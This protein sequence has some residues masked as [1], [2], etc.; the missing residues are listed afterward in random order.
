MN[1]AT[2]EVLKTYNGPNHALICA[3]TKAYVAFDDA[4][5]ELREVKNALTIEGAGRL[6]ALR[7]DAQ[8]RL[9][10]VYAARVAEEVKAVDEVIAAVSQNAANAKH[11][12]KSN[13]VAG[14]V[15]FVE[16]DSGEVLQVFKR[17]EHGDVE[18]K[19]ASEDDR[20]VAQRKATKVFNE[21]AERF[22]ILRG[23]DEPLDAA[24]RQNE[25]EDVEE[26]PF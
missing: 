3:L 2:Y 14:R 22:A 19:T 9:L 21:V 16:L 5:T 6:L 7:S 20:H 12:I 24:E 15:Y 18:I 11:T 23:F 8:V 1:E 4:R 13:A 10:E 26:V 25:D 17:Y